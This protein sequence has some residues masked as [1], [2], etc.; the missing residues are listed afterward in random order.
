MSESSPIRCFSL[1]AILVGLAFV[2]GFVTA[3]VKHHNSPSSP[4]TM[5]PKEQ[6]NIRPARLP[7]AAD[8][9]MD[10]AL[11]MLGRFGERPNSET[12][13]DEI[14]TILL[15]WAAVDPTAALEYV[16]H[17]FDPRHRN[18]YLSSILA[19]WAKSNP[20][21]AWNWATKELPDDYTQYDAVL[22]EV[23][24]TDPDTAWRFAAEL[25]GQKGPEFAQ[26]IYVSALR[27]LAYTGQYQKAAELI[28][29]TKLPQDSEEFNMSSFLAG[30]WSRY[31]PQKAAEWA[32]NLGD[33]TAA[34]QWAMTS[35][36]ASWAKSDPQAVADFA[37]QLPSGVV[38]QNMMA[39]ALGSWATDQ[40]DQVA[41][42][43][44]Q[45]TYDPDFDQV[46]RSMAIS[47]KV[48]AN[49]QVAIAWANVIMDDNIR[50]QTLNLIM[51]QWLEQDTEA[52]NAY[53]KTTTDLSPE[54][55]QQ[56]RTD[57]GNLYQP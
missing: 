25:A 40:P 9:A 48:A 43:L 3:P 15:K 36:G 30:E 6:T 55:L 14:L 18:L 51:R 32:N 54:M 31:D 20:Q 57:T 49:P 21:A 8:E 38:R 33:G 44:N 47:P 1:N 56:V 13:Y 37:A 46:V 26:T 22:A 24:R 12:A 16:R 29:N 2:A 23:G 35:L 10:S 4:A 45:H 42:W 17:H 5:P 41:A 19:Q 11:A 50:L 28:A 39:T 27:G 7:T 53:L 34:R 52:A